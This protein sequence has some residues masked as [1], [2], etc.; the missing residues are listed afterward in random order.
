M[1]GF[2]S[3]KL[4]AIVRTVFSPQILECK[5]KINFTVEKALCPSSS[6]KVLAQ[7]LQEDSPIITQKQ[8]H[9]PQHSTGSAGQ[10]L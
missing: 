9:C 8:F 5:L 1:S 4:I 7:K 2:F 3:L 10:S 6:L